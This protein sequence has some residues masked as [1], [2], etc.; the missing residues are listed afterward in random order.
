M[1]GKGERGKEKKKEK[2]PGA[3]YIIKHGSTLIAS[4]TMQGRGGSRNKGKGRKKK[5]VAI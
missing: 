5:K 4:S 3:D 2:A 1:G